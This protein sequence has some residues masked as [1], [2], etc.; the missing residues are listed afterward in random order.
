[1]STFL[2]DEIIFGPVRS[3]RLGISLGINLLPNHSKICNFNCIYCE[4]GWTPGVLPD[5]NNF[6]PRKN[7]ETALHTRLKIM[8]DKDE[9]LNSITFAGNGEPTMHPDFEGII[10]DTINARNMYFPETRVAVLSNSTLIQK[11]SVFKALQK[12]DDAI[13]KLDSVFEKTI[14]FLNQ[15]TEHFSINETIENLKK[16]NGDFILQ[17][18]FI[19]GYN[20]DFEID[21][22]QSTE[23]EAWLKLLPEINPR[24]IMIYT[25]ARDT[26]IKTLEKIPLSELNIIASRVKKSGFNVQVSG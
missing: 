26:P 2:F 1:M 11:N 10:N 15:P 23:L 24:L 21:N 8:R 17:T 3:R 16:F 4:C 6:H 25:I 22:T 20:N 13:M 5:F 7:I 9:L 19:K 18:M 14:K 12:V